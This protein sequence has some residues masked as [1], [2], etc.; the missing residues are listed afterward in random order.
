MFPLPQI[1]LTQRNGL[2]HLDVSAK[3]G[4]GIDNLIHQLIDIALKQMDENSV[5][6]TI[7]NGNN[8]DGSDALRTTLK[9]NDELDLHK[10]YGPKSSSCFPLSFQ[11]CR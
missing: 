1:T 11:C 5:T 8:G 3:S 2:I 10:R 4:V 6:K 9:H 7:L